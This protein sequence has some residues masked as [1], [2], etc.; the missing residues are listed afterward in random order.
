MQP[1]H[2]NFIPSMITGSSQADIAMLVISARKGESLPPLGDSRDRADID[3]WMGL[4]ASSRLVSI[5]VDRVESGCQM[6]SLVRGG[7]N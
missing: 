1:G 6:N 2:K 7:C 5:G 3:G 4:Q